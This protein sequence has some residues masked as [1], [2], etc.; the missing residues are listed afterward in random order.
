MHRRCMC[1]AG[2]G[3]GAPLHRRRAQQEAGEAQRGRG[4]A[5]AARLLP[6]RAAA[7]QTRHQ[8]RGRAGACACAVRRGGAKAL[9]GT[10]DAWR[11]T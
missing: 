9:G 5:A 1:V 8:V 3:R 11:G 7:S 6:P 10:L 2:A 4:D